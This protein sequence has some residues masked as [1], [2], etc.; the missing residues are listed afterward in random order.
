MF[1]IRKECFAASCSVDPYSP[2]IAV[3]LKIEKKI[4]KT[5]VTI[6]ALDCFEEKR[7]LSSLKLLF[8]FTKSNIGMNNEKRN[9]PYNV[10]IFTDLK[11]NKVLT[12]NITRMMPRYKKKFNFKV[13]SEDKLKILSV[14][15]ISFFLNTISKTLTDE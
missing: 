8:F 13:V 14:K 4:R 5:I 6:N 1:N 2:I 11:I 9:I 7:R 12:Y 15:V 10:N 3:D